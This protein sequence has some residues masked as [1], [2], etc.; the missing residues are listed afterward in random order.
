MIYNGK[1]RQMFPLLFYLPVHILKHLPYFICRRDNKRRILK[2]NPLKN[3]RV[4]IRL[5]PYYKV[6]KKAALEIETRRKKAKAGIVD[7]KR[8]VS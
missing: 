4:M 7:E 2:K 8:G 5:N 3:Q 1:A 6:T